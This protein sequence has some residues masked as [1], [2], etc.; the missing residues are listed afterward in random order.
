MSCLITRTDTY[1]V[2][3]YEFH[4]PFFA[5]LKWGRVILSTA[6]ATELTFSID[7]LADDVVH[8]YV[9]VVV[10]L[11]SG[12]LTANVAHVRLLSG[13]HLF[14]FGQVVAARKELAAHVAFVAARL[15]VLAHVANAVVFA[16]ELATADVARVRAAVV[17]GAHVRVVVDLVDICL[18]AELA[19]EGLGAARHVRP[20]VQL[21]VPLGAK[22]AR[23]LGAGERFNI[24]VDLH[25]RL[26]RRVQIADVADGALDQ[27]HLFLGHPL[28]D[29][30]LVVPFTDVPRQAGRVD[31]AFDAERALLGLLV[32]DLAVPQ[33]LHLAVE[34]FTAVADEIL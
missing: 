7:R 18:D 2:D 28:G 21:Q 26:Q 13:V 19:L 34:H 15:L 25:V 29:V 23:T 27:V 6:A 24:V 9:L 22:A 8:F 16:N 17:V 14:M 12:R 20:L 11:G 3:E 30:R 5:I 32:V 4:V 1:D 10:G 33:Q 31:K